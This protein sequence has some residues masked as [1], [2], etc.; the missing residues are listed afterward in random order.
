VAALVSSPADTVVMSTAAVVF[1]V[2]AS[3]VACKHALV[4]TFIHMLGQQANSQQK[5][6]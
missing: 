3:L 4:Y 6:L 5:V 2:Q 1:H